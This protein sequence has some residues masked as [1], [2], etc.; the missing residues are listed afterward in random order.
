MTTRIVT[1]LLTALLSCAAAADPPPA[2]VEIHYDTYFGFI[3]VGE[4][5]DVMEHD[6]HSYHLVSESRTVGLAALFHELVIHREAQ[7]RIGPGGLAPVSFS[8]TDNGKFK[9]GGRFDWSAH[10]AM[11]RDDHGS[12]I[13]PLH[14]NSWDLTSFTYTFA[15]NPPG[16][17]D[18]DVYLASGRRMSRFR[19]TISGREKIDTGAGTLDTLHVRKILEG[20]DKRAFDLW[21]AVN[22]HYLPVKIRFTSKK[23]NVF[24]S[25]ASSITTSAH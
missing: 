16:R 23:G 19:Y 18:M 8:E 7:G 3:K 6:N 2:R 20:G 22:R 13:I 9:Y 1:A 11:V 15:F 24:S 14:D 12:D 4:T 21:L 5:R 10:Q 25:I 17:G